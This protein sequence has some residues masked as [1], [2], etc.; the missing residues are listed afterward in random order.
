MARCGCATGFEPQ[1]GHA[2]HCSYS[3]FCQL[4]MTLLIISACSKCS[5][6][7]NVG[8]TPADLPW[9]SPLHRQSNILFIKCQEWIWWKHFSECRKCVV[10]EVLKM[11]EA[12]HFANAWRMLSEHF[13]KLCKTL[14]EMFIKYKMGPRFAPVDVDPD[15]HGRK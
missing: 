13:P 4:Y 8:E 11:S 12:K 2:F 5:N 6:S 3:T 15:M 1:L 10:R 7:S 9:H 14:S